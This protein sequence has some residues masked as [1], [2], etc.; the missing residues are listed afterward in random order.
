[1]PTLIKENNRFRLWKNKADWSIDPIGTNRL[2]LYKTKREALAAWDR[3]NEPSPSQKIID[4]QDGRDAVMTA[5][6]NS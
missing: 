5:F 2:L 4:A 1:M 6:L 3:L